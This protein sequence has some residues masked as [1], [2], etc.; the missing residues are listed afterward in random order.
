MQVVLYIDP[1]TGKV[2][3]VEFAFLPQSKYA[4]IPP[5][6][7]YEMTEELKKNIQVKMTEAGKN[8]NYDV[9]YWMHSFDLTAKPF[10]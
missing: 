6:T 10:W 1:P 5:Q 9:Y 4:F 7:Y 2:T 3:Y 8:M